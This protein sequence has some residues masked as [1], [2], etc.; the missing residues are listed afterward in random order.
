MALRCSFVPLSVI[1]C[2][3]FLVNSL[4]AF[5]AIY[6]DGFPPR[7]SSSLNSDVQALFELKTLITGESSVWYEWNSSESPCGWFGVTCEEIT[8]DGLMMEKRIVGLQLESKQLKGSLSPAIG[9]LSELKMLSLANNMLVGRIPKDI[10]D[11]LKLD[12]LDLRGNKLSGPIPPE[13]TNL[14]RLKVLHLSDNTLSGELSFLSFRNNPHVVSDP[15]PH[16]EYLNLA[17]NR[18][19]GMIP[20][21][22]ARISA[23]ES[24]I[25]HSN[26]L[27][28]SIPLSLGSLQSLKVLHLH[29]NFLHGKLP[30]SLATNSSKLQSLDVSGNFLV[31]RIPSSFGEVKTLRFLNVSNN[32]LEGPIPWGA[33]FKYGAD[34]SA[35]SRNTRLCGRPLKSCPKSATLEW[36]SSSSSSSQSSEQDQ[37][38]KPQSQ[39][40]VSGVYKKLRPKPLVLAAQKTRFL[41]E[42][43]VAPSAG[44][45]GSSITAGHALAP[46]PIAAKSE[47]KKKKHFLK[48]WGLGMGIGILT[49][50]ISAVACSFLYRTLVYYSRGR[51]KVQGA[52]IYSSLIKKAEDLKFLETEEGLRS[53]NLIGKGG[54][55]E[56]YKAQLP[57]GREIAIKK[58]AQPTPN[59]TDVSDEDTKLLDKRRR[60]IRAELETL[61]HIRHRNLVTLLAYIARPDCHLLVYEYMKNGSLQQAL[62]RVAEGT[63]ELSWPVR[64]KIALGIA[65]GLSYLHFHSTPKIIH[66]DLKPGNILLDENFDAHVADFGLAKALPEAATHA[67]SSNVAGTVG[68]IAPEYHQTLKFTD[69]CDVYSFGVVLAVLVTGKQPYDEF[70]QTIPQASIPKWLRNVVASESASSAIDPQLKGQGFDDEIFLV[71]KIACFCT[72]DDPNKRPNSREV[73]SMLTQLSS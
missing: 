60:Q 33:W 36:S 7:G 44:R 43:A 46:A 26:L 25:L 16:L 51:P 10:A 64:H 3:V 6:E 47:H 18:L 73:L 72:D 32:N 34:P 66:R 69:K 53:E 31:G 68:Y 62:Q 21:G 20:S 14:R 67:T 1:F 63:L 17:N 27:V 65:S 13:F 41:T 52:V 38:Q 15:F 50:A 71:M 37:L 59:P 2:I 11:C 24:I 45:N 39:S 58:I 42:K 61:G 22:I 4:H 19:T 55:G 8:I 12:I 35:F 57:D 29:N 9:R 54:S 40:F 56:V 23:L 49:G 5:K 70:F 28:G 30:P 48:K